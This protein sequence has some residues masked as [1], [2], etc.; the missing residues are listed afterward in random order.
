M[1]TEIKLITSKIAKEL[2]ERNNIN[3]KLSPLMIS[4][5][6]RQMSSGLWKECTGEAIKISEN[7]TLLDGQHRLEALIHSNMSLEFLII[8]ELEDDVFTVIDTGRSRGAGDLL[9]IANIP[10][11][12]KIAAGIKKYYLFK[13]GRIGLD[14][15]GGGAGDKF[16]AR[17]SNQEVLNIYQKRPEFWH[18][19]NMMA[20]DWYRKSLHILSQ[21]AFLSL[22]AFLNDI[23]ENEAFKFM[24]LLG[25]GI[26][27]MPK[28]PIK[29]L[30]DK[31]TFFK[32]NNKITMTAS[33]K[34]ALIFKTWNY[35][36]DGKISIRTLSYSI[37]S[38]AFPI[39]K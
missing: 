36:R 5:Y 16:R 35:F 26:G 7:G 21:S 1:K 23:N 2:L 15:S 33:Y 31:L 6:S 32:I 28:H 9:E 29:L 8:S 37:N 12:T 39:P 11:S 34:T 4:E 17:L 20:A 10:D 19:A 18:N 24:D 38:E 22:F 13:V 3:R 27:L 30:R 14:Q 25:Q